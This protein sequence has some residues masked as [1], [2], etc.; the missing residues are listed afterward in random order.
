MKKFFK[1]CVALVLI[2]A[3]LAAVVHHTNFEGL[4]R[5]IHGG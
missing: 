5:K 3:V 2:L 4:M 1:Y